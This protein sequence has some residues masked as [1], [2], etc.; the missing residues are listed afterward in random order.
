MLNISVNI[1]REHT[2]KYTIS[3]ATFR[4]LTLFYFTKGAE[5]KNNNNCESSCIEVAENCCT[6][7]SLI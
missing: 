3:A 6:L 4:L 1:N 7:L 5:Q 2:R